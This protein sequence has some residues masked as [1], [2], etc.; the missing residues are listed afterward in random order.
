MG[1]IKDSNSF[2]LK[3]IFLNVCLMIVDKIQIQLDKNKSFLILQNI[4][5]QKL[6]DEIFSYFKFK[7]E[8]MFF[9]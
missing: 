3:E 1:K 2:R 4:Y 8:E 6:Y 5:N 7:L 9:D